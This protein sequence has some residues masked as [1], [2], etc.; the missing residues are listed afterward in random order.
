MVKRE[1]NED[2]FLKEIFDFIESHK[3]T[4]NSKDYIAVEDL[5]KFQKILYGLVLEDLE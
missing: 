4:C 5:P 2:K 1:F 3:H